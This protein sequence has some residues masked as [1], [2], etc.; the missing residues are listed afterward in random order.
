[1]KHKRAGRHG[2]TRIKLLTEATANTQAYRFSVI[3]PAEANARSCWDLQPALPLP[4]TPGFRGGELMPLPTTYARLERVNKAG[5]DFAQLR[6][7]GKLLK[8][9][10][11]C[12]RN[13]LY[14]RDAFIV[15]EDD[16][17]QQP[18]GHWSDR[19]TLP[20][21][22]G[23]ELFGSIVIPHCS[24]GMLTDQDREVLETFSTFLAIS[25]Q[26]LRRE[27]E[28]RLLASTDPLTGVLNR[29]HFTRISEQTLGRERSTCLIV[30]DIDAFKIVNDRCGHLAG[31][32]V[33]KSVA[34]RA[35]ENL[36]RNDVVARYG[37]DEFVILLPD[38]PLERAIDVAERIRLAI[39]A[40]PV[41]VNGKQVS[42]TISAGVSCI[43]GETNLEPLIQHADQALYIAKRDGGNSVQCAR[44]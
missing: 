2:H 26:N 21:S 28:L 41:E 34:Q 32:I 13:D 19:I 30:F 40:V 42:C 44:C 17:K 9:A 39:E 29:R 7:I 8:A 25:L 37:G 23:N 3:S 16:G 33:L 11:T 14:F 6:S 35:Q 5:R 27:S 10:V 4:A 18:L 12:L 20:V 43:P 24:N 22:L 31:D 36:R 38:T 1:M 15:L